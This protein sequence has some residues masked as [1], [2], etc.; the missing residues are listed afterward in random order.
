MSNLQAEDHKGLNS[1]ED[2]SDSG[3]VLNRAF[4][5]EDSHLHF[6][7]SESVKSAILSISDIS[8]IVYP[9]G[10]NSPHFLVIEE[11]ISGM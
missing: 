1:C 7:D 8:A 11:E 4:I 10:K 9:N 2:E 5:T 6:S 3:N